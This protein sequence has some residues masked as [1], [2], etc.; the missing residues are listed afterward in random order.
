MKV[1]DLILIL[2]QFDPDATLLYAGEDFYIVDTASVVS[3]D[4]L[5]TM[6][7]EDNEAG[8]VILR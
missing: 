6:V 2:Q 3:R 1:N 8:G 5:K 4:E 7:D